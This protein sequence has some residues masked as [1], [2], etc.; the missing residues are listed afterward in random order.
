M[1]LASRYPMPLN[2]NVLLNAAMFTILFF[3]NTLASLLH[4]VFDVRVAIAVDVVLTALSVVSVIVW[5]FALTMKGEKER[6]ELVHY[7]P[8][9]EVRILQRLDQINRLVLRLPSRVYGT[10]GIAGVGRVG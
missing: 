7:R 9:D 8:E 10:G 4:T 1:L 2:R 5:F 3:A 6:I